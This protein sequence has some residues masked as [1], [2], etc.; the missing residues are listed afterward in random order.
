MTARALLA[1]RRL[2]LQSETL[3]EEVETER[4]AHLS[5]CAPHATVRLHLR[6]FVTAGLKLGLAWQQRAAP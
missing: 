2:S 5:Q 1:F 6:S 3:L 4:G